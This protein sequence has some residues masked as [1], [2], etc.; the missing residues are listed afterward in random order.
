MVN[1]SVLVGVL[2]ARAI[3][4]LLYYNF[5]KSS[6]NLIN[7]VMDHI[8][9]LKAQASIRDERRRPADPGRPQFR[10]IPN[11]GDGEQEPVEEFPTQ[12]IQ[13]DENGGLE[14][15][16]LSPRSIPNNG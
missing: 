7:R 12:S 5:E 4:P 9:C 11:N 6:T 10:P 3:N 13:N 2:V 8:N 15:L 14:N 16:E 1:P